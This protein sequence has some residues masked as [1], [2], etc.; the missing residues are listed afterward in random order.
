[1][2]TRPHRVGRSKTQAEA[3]SKKQVSYLCSI[4]RNTTQ[5]RLDKQPKKVPK[6][7]TT[8]LAQ[9][10]LVIPLDTILATTRTTPLSQ[11][12][13]RVMRVRRIHRSL[14]SAVLVKSWSKRM[15][16]TAFS[17]QKKVTSFSKR[18]RSTSCK[19]IRRG[20]RGTGARKVRDDD[21]NY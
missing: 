15:G 16:L 3:S 8:P 20:V 17:C 21:M 11:V 10:R 1:M 4:W 14:S 13:L 7:A 6:R 9:T 18:G 12:A 19:R 2:S 5:R